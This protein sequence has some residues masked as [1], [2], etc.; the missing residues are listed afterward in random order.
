[1]SEEGTFSHSFITLFSS[2]SVILNWR[3]LLW[4]WR[5]IHP[6]NFQ[7]GLGPVTMQATPQ[8]ELNFS[9]TTELLSYSNVWKHYPA[10]TPKTLA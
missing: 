4:I 9:E 1:M 10:D 5:K 2:S 6:K 8:D 7:F 3:K